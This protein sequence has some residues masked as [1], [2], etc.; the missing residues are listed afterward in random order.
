MIYLDDILML[1]EVHG[2]KDLLN[3]DTQDRSEAEESSR[4]VKVN[5]EQQEI[6]S[7][8]DTGCHAM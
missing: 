1:A 6:P 3:S 7:E 2:R 5:C 8:G 4:V